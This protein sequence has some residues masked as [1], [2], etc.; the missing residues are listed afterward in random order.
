MELPLPILS[1]QA[2]LTGSAATA[3]HCNRVRNSLRQPAFRV[4]FW[5]AHVQRRKS[6]HHWR[7][8]AAT[9]GNEAV[10]SDVELIPA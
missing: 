6:T 9:R 4:Q 8:T 10:L 5:M 2:L 3:I 1:Q 7:I